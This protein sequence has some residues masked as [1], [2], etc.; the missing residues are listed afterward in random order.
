MGT[1]GGLSDPTL[2]EARS[3]QLGNSTLAG[4]AGHFTSLLAA[5]A[6]QLVGCLIDPLTRPGVSHLLPALLWELVGDIGSQPVAPNLL[7]L[8]RLRAP[9]AYSPLWLWLPPTEP[10]SPALGPAGSGVLR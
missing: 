1:S 5:A 10:L 6:A 7:P 9:S 3:L 4:L 8:S 2:P